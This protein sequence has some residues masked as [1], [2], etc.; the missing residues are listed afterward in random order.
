LPSRREFFF[1]AAAAALTV[2]AHAQTPAASGF[3]PMFDGTI[4]QWTVENTQANNFTVRDGAALDI[5]CN[6]K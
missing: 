5:L 6:V 3:V 4:D 1:T 2:P